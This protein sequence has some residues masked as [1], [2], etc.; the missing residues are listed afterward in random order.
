MTCILGTT[1]LDTEFTIEKLA[2]LQ[3]ITFRLCSLRYH[4]RWKIE[5][6]FP[7]PN[8]IGQ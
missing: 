4:D 5:T 6:Y 2:K 8:I 7:C 3:A 1:L